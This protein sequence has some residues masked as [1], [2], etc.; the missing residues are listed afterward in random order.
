MPH[1]AKSSKPSDTMH[2]YTLCYHALDSNESPSDIQCRADRSVIVDE[3]GF[4][5]QLQCLSEMDLPVVSL[6]KQLST[7]AA[8]DKKRCVVL[9]FD[10]GHNSNYSLAMPALLD[11]RVT[12]TFYVISGFVDKD[13]DYLTSRQLRE[14]AASGMLIGS[15]TMTHRWLPQLSGM[16]IQQ[17]L[18]DSKAKLEDI[19]GRPVLDFALPGGHGNRRIFEVARQSGYRSVAT[20]QVGVF[21]SGSD[22]FHI[23][24]LEIRRGLSIEGFQ[25]TFSARKLKQLQFIEC[26]KSFVRR[27]LGLSNYTR[28]RKVVHR[29]VTINR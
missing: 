13:P 29:F 19:I 11:A 25:N 6:E 4:R 24:R 18:V 16:E 22:P 7:K 5:Q 14:L 26:G 1:G 23:P 2:A 28:L 8:D 9:T 27:S 17:E 15:H 12:A 20:C 3:R 10:D 21:Q